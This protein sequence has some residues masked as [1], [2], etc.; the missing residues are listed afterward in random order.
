MNKTL[1]GVVR[2][3]N[4][5][6]TDV[7]AGLVSIRYYDNNEFADIDNGCVLKVGALEGDANIGYER[8]IFKGTAPAAND[9]LKD[10]VLI[11]S[12]E[13]MYDERLRGLTDFYN[14]AGKA[15]RGYRFHSG[16]IFSVTKTVLDGK[17]TPAVGDIVELKAGIKMNVAASATSGSTQVGKI[18]AVDV[19]GQIT[20]YAIQVG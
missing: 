14:V 3:D 13:V 2:T 15:C 16:D 12:P 4:M 7:R 10:V 9:A 8:E 17:E 11:A 20:Y 5:Y 18:I 1:H 6:G 19:V